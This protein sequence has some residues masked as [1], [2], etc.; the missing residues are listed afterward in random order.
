MYIPALLLVTFLLGAALLFGDEAID[1]ETES[2]TR[3][4]VTEVV[5]ETGQLS[6][7]DRTTVAFEIGGRIDDL[8]IEEEDGVQS[9]E[10]LA[11]LEDST[12]VSELRSARAR[13]QA[14]E[15]RLRELEAGADAPDRRV[16]Q[17]SLESAHV[18]LDDAQENLRDVKREQNRAVLNARRSL[19]STDLQARL[20]GGAREDSFRSYDPPTVT[21]TYEGDEEGEYRITLFP[22]GRESGYSIRYE[23][24]ESGVSGVSTVEPQPLGTKGLSIRFPVNFARNNSL[25][26]TVTIPNRDSPQYTANRNAYET[27]LENQDTA[28]ESAERAVEQARSAYEEALARHERTLSPVRSEQV[29]VQH[30]QVEQARAAVEG[31]ERSLSRTVLEAP[32]SGTITHVDVSRGQVVSAGQSIA[33]LR[34]HDL[35]IILHVPEADIAN[36]EVGDHAYVRFDAFRDT[37]FRAVVTSIA[38][39]ARQVDGIASFKT[40]LVLDD[41]TDPRLRA[42]LTADV[43]IVTLERSDVFTVPSRAVQERDGERYVRILEGEEMRW[44]PVRTGVRGV[45]GRIEI[46]GDLSEGDTIVTFIR[47]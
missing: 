1:I 17:A 21:G 30:A 37:E 4:N 34:S 42:G 13:L 12:H 19:L 39:S 23:G 24:I 16:S 32:F 9:G 5:T 43:D 14:E 6:A 8:S 40:T 29:E 38:S 41:S 15:A 2:L 10:R 45:D 18:R 3:Q 47:E 7:L 44:V 28:I 31:A 26:W 27:A 33:E 20:T 46:E 22:S 35:E 25:E 11:S 36:V